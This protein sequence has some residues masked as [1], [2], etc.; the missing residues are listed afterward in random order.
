[1]SDDEDDDDGYEGAHIFQVPLPPE[2][3]EQAQRAQMQGFVE[4]TAFRNWLHESTVE[5]LQMF[6]AV[7]NNVHHNASIGPYYL[8]LITGLLDAVH[9]IS[10]V[11]G[12]TDEQR[13]REAG[14]N[15]ASG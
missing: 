5:E 4:A 13:L 3:I 2:F 9:G 12:K 11:D 1:M 7:L 10:L 6:Y 15:D 8:G 14:L